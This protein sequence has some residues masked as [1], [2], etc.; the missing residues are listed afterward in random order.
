MTIK[1]IRPGLFS[2]FQDTG[3]TGF[4]H[5]G[6]PVNG[7]MDQDA[8]AL[9]N[10]LVGNPT[11]AASL[12]ITLQ[13]PVL[14]FQAKALIALAGADLGARLDGVVLKPGQ[15]ICVKPGA[16]LSFEKARIR[17]AGLLG[18]QRW[19]PA[20]T[21]DEQCQHLQPRRVRWAVRA[22]AQSR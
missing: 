7:A 8:H 2:S 11:R 1:V 17:C 19:L 9:A 10:L 13:G 16:V 18:R 14:C 22:R 12:E 21:G 5:W 20:A 3:R 15:A 4:Q 6:V